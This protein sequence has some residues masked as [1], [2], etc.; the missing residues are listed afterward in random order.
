VDFLS[1]TTWSARFGRE[2]LT[3]P[4]GSASEAA[5]VGTGTFGQSTGPSA[6]AESALSEGSQGN[7]QFHPTYAISNAF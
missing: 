6:A 1:G 3:E 4:E 2:R 5:D 7:P